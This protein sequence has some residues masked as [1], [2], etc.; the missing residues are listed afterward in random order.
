VHLDAGFFA[1]KKPNLTNRE[2][3]QSS[4]AEAEQLLY[5]QAAS[6]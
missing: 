6:K 4:E 1:S 2:A 5:F 3:E